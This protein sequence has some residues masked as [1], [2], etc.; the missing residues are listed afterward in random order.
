MLEEY[1][2]YI[3]VYISIQHKFQCY[4][5]W[6]NCKNNGPM[7]WNYSFFSF[8][9]IIIPSEYCMVS[10]PIPQFKPLSLENNDTHIKNKLFLNV[11][12]N[13]TPLLITCSVSS[14]ISGQ[15]RAILNIL[16]EPSNMTHW[17][18]ALPDHMGISGAR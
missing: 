12:G 15:I 7:N 5:I 9:K 8:E 14:K 3:V 16:F 17:P 10:I 13:T 6:N 2:Y 11:D 1:D 18:P 4:P